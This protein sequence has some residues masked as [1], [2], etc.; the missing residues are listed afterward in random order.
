MDRKPR[1]TDEVHATNGDRNLR[2]RP[3][4]APRIE[5]GQKLVGVTG[6]NQV[7]GQTT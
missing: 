3:Y 1:R 7:T 5:K 2:P 6:L 4:V